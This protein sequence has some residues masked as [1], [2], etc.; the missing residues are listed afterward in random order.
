MKTPEEFL[1]DNGF[2]KIT[3]LEGVIRVFS[4][5]EDWNETVYEE[6]E[7]SISYESGTVKIEIKAAE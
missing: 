2:E 7:F 3:S 6:N 4:E 1:K 5:D